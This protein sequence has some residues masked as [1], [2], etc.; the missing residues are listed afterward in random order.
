MNWKIIALLGLAGVLPPLG[1]YALGA[2]PLVSVV[3]WTLLAALVW[4]PV[5]L[6]SRVA[7][8]FVTLVLVGLVSGV[9]AG[10]VDVIMLGDPMLLVFALV[11]GAAWGALFGG[12]AAGIR[13]WRGP[14]VERP[15]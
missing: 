12:V 2:S 9:A 10:V 5:I 11:V 3:L 14:A 13:R 4:V 6:R 7:Q 1:S 15:T 8:P